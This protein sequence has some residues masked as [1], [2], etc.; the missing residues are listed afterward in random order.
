MH[1][2]AYATARVSLWNYMHVRIRVSLSYFPSM[3]MVRERGQGKSI[4]YLITISPYTCIL[5]ARLRPLCDFSARRGY[6][7]LVNCQAIEC[8]SSLFSVYSIYLWNKHTEQRRGS[9]NCGFPLHLCE[10]VIKM[11]N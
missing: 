1:L 11:T 7:L 3:H 6:N 10:G 2:L 4:F 9:Y 5:L 8:F